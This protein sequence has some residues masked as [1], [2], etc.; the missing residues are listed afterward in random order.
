MLAM[1]AD[2]SYGFVYALTA[3]DNRIIYVELIFCNYFMDIDY[4]S[5]INRKYLPLGFDATANNLYR[6]EIMREEYAE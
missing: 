1:E 4:Q 2:S 5:M 6:Q 3:D